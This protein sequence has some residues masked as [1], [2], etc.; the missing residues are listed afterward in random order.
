[1][2]AFHGNHLCESISKAVKFHAPAIRAALDRAKT[3]SLKTT[4]YATRLQSTSKRIETHCDTV[5]AEIE[6]FV[7]S[8]V[9]AVEEHRS[10]LHK[11]VEQV[12]N[13]KL[14]KLEKQKREAIRRLKDT[15]DAV[16]FVDELLSEGT[17][18]EIL[19]FLK[20]VI[21]RL[22]SCSGG[23]VDFVVQEAADVSDGV[24]FLPDEVARNFE[25]CCP[26]YGVVTTQSACPKHCT[27]KEDGE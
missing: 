23:R 19:S 18:V 1:M 24:Q 8:Y 12:R 21:K 6:R 4:T 11:Q 26:I 7:R 17:D 10:R 15:N 14:K 20:P 22:E 9:A 3:V 5:Q 2:Q 16:S 27:L 25:S 13:D